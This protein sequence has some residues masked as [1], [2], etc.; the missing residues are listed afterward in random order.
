MKHILTK[1]KIE[2]DYIWKKS[3]ENEPLAK[4]KQSFEGRSPQYPYENDENK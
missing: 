1:L 2:N 4:K 3:T